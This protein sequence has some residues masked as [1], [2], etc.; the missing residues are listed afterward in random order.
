MLASIKGERILESPNDPLLFE[1]KSCSAY[2]YF[3]KRLVFF[4]TGSSHAS[5]HVHSNGE[6]VKSPLIAEEAFYKN[7]EQN[8][9]KTL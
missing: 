7:L 8:S 9:I 2:L 1:E 4:E 6:N 3:K 5:S